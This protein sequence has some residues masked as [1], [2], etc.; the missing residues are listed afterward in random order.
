MCTFLPSL[1]STS[2]TVDLT[3]FAVA[4]PFW[5]LVLASESRTVEL[6]ESVALLNSDN[7][8]NTK[9]R[10]QHWS[11]KKTKMFKHIWYVNWRPLLLKKLHACVDSI[12]DKSLWRTNLQFEL[13]SHS[14]TN[15]NVLWEY[16]FPSLHPAPA[17]TPQT[18]LKTSTLISPKFQQCIG[19]GG[20][21]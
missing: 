9:N 20:G 5:W 3:C 17:P 13:S 2:Q 10:Q 1:W 15:W 16:N 4:G 18:G 12:M 14:Q 19:G 7:Y 21:K 8:T 6:F 11:V